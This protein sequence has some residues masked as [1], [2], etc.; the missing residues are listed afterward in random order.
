MKL[1]LGDKLEI[2]VRDGRLLIGACMSV[3]ASLALV[4][5]ISAADNSLLE[6]LLSAAFVISGLFLIYQSIDKHK[7][8]WALAADA[9]RVTGS[10]EPSRTKSQELDGTTY[11]RVV[12]SYLFQGLTYAH[13]VETSS[14]E[15]YGSQELIFIQ[16]SRPENAVF[17]ADLP[18]VVREKLLAVTS[19]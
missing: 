15:K 19:L 12:Y 1:P 7:S 17:S 10:F 11:Y 14:P 8:L 6:L 4:D 16:R 2:M 5:K 3:T 13:C 18:G 9:S